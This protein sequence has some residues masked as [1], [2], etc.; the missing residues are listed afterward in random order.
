MIL[1]LLVLSFYLL[2][3]IVGHLGAYQTD[4]SYIR[5]VL[6]AT[7]LLSGALTLF[8][9]AQY[10]EILAAAVGYFAILVVFL[11]NIPQGQ[12]Q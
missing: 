4:P 5:V 12:L 8:A 6:V 3:H 1:D 9:R 11:G 7:V 10:D 2:Y